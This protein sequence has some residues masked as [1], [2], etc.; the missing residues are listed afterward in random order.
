MQKRVDL[1]NKL[2]SL[3]IPKCALDDLLLAIVAERSDVTALLLARRGDAF[4]SCLSGL[5]FVAFSIFNES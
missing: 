2:H 5:S 1:I 3:R 4:N